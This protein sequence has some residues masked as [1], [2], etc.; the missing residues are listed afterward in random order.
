MVRTQKQLKLKLNWKMFQVC[1][2][3]GPGFD[4]RLTTKQPQK[5]AKN[6]QC[7]HTSV[8]AGTVERLC[9]QDW[10][11]GNCG[12]QQPAS[13]VFQYYFCQTTRLCES[14]YHISHGLCPH[15]YNSAFKNVFAS[16]NAYKCGT[17][18]PPTVQL[19]DYKMG[20][21]ESRK[22]WAFL[23]SRLSCDN[24]FTNFFFVFFSIRPKIVGDFFAPTT[25]L[26][27]WNVVSGAI[28]SDDIVVDFMFWLWMEKSLAAFQTKINYAP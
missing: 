16:N 17:L 28:K 12:R 3:A 1:E 25:A 27:P 26:A 8:I 22:S 14:S 9:H 10:M 21:S 4:Y 6:V 24:L 13:N 7:I 11:M 23:Y 18:R 5:A 2:P 15:Y 19:T 20:Y